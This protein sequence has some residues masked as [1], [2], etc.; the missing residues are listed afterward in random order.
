MVVLL[1]V[2]VPW[3]VAMALVV[4]AVVATG[5]GYRVA[6]LGVVE[7]TLVVAQLVEMRGAGVKGGGSVELEKVG[8]R[9]AAMMAEA[10]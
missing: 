4:T 5:E 3:E 7:V 10:A 1:A 8:E 6:E 2:G 9:R